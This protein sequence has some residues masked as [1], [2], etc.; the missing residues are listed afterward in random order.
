MASLRISKMMKYDEIVKLYTGSCF[1]ATAIARCPCFFLPMAGSTGSTQP[2]HPSAVEVQEYTPTWR[3]ISPC[4]F[5]AQISGP[6]QLQWSLRASK[7]D[8]MTLMLMCLMV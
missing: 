2:S 5:R 3:S 7:P 1:L 4:V 8:L 6:N